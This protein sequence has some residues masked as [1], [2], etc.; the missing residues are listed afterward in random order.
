LQNKKCSKVYQKV[1]AKP[2]DDKIAG[3]QYRSGD[4]IAANQVQ[5]RAFFNLIRLTTSE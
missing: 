5:A 4:K 3:N 2:A 1:A